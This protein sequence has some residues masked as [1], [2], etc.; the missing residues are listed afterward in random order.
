MANGG[1]FEG[2]WP[3]LSLSGITVYI[4]H[5]LAANLVAHVIGTHMPFNLLEK[6]CLGG[7][8]SRLHNSFWYNFLKAIVILFNSLYVFEAYMLLTQVSPTCQ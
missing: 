6:Y 7:L 3:F 4:V 2:G 8:G 5:M 1:E